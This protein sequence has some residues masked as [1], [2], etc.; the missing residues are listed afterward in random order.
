MNYCSHCVTVAIL[1]G[2]CPLA[3]WRTKLRTPA[4]RRNICVREYLWRLDSLLHDFRSVFCFG[5]CTKISHNMATWWLH[6]QIY[7]WWTNLQ[8]QWVA[9]FTTADGGLG[10]PLCSLPKSSQLQTILY[11]MSSYSLLTLTLTTYSKSE[12]LSVD[13]GIF[14]IGVHWPVVALRTGCE[15][16]TLCSTLSTQQKIANATSGADFTGH[17]GTCPHFYKWLGTGEGTV[18][19]RTACTRN[20]PSCND[21]HEN[22]HQND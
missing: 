9:G 14:S 2:K 20:L 13:T 7:S 4:V 3:V 18:S 10:R 15:K 19:T 6:W 22:T 21:H 1:Q 11:S 12:E 8:M 17:G 5:A 16:F